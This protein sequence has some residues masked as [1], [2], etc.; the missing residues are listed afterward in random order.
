MGN[1]LR[2]DDRIPVR[3]AAREKIMRK[4]RKNRSDTVFKLGVTVGIIVLLLVCGYWILPRLTEDPAPPP[5]APAP[6]AAGPETPAVPKAPGR[7]TPAPAPEIRF[8][9]KEDDLRQLMERRKR[10]YGLDKGVD[11]IAREGERITVGDITVPM[12]EIVDKIRGKEG[13]ISESDLVSADGLLPGRVDI[14]QLFSRLKEAEASLKKLERDDAGKSASAAA[15]G[16]RAMD[17]RGSKN[18]DA[19]KKRLSAIVRDFA[20]YKDTLR[21]LHEKETLAAAADFQKALGERIDDLER[22]RGAE[23]AAFLTRWRQVMGDTEKNTP[24]GSGKDAASSGGKRAKTSGAPPEAMSLREMR[25]RVEI[26]LER[27][28]NAVSRFAGDPAADTDREIVR[29]E[30]LTA[31]ITRLEQITR[32]GE[33]YRRLAAV[34]P[35][36]AKEK[37]ADNIQ[38]LRRERDDLEAS[39]VERVMPGRKQR[40]YGIY[41]VR[42]GDNIWNIH[43]RFLSEYAAARGL[44][45]TADADEPLA[46]GISSGVGKILKFAENMVYIYNLRERELSED[47]HLIHPLSK[48]VIFNLNQVVDLLDQLDR[49]N[50]RHIRYDGENLWISPP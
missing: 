16:A 26:R 34:S 38:A 19:E 2:R 39:L 29:L 37:L 12:T 8:R 50:I 47:L 10:E 14:E 18:A 13:K 48:I 35:K 41:V 11:M 15:P 40:I 6:L 46:P 9:E 33:E 5:A 44:L 24:A 1:G 20:S 27:R 30:E 25:D 49:E 7:K 28:R 23:M 45:L 42:P 36:A 32:R 31:A 3:R 4:I 21:E 22:R 43:F 17:G